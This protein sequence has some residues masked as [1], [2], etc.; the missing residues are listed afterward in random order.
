MTNGHLSPVGDTSIANDDASYDSGSD[1]SEIREAPVIEASPSVSST[2]HRP[3]DFDNED[4][5]SSEES[6][7]NNDN[8]SDDG[9][10]DVEESIAE[11]THRSARIDRSSS[12]DSRRPTKRKLGIEDDQYIK[13]NPE[14]YGLRRSVR[15]HTELWSV[16]LTW[17][18]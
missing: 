1:L 13:A 3:Y 5:E 4:A 8:G 14:L 2:P 17:L 9:D 18:F 7:D 16:S 6:D 12:H 15:I 11:T 10:F